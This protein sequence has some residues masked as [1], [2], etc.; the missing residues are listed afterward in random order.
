M[1]T[2][3]ISEELRTQVIELLNAYIN[4]SVSM[5]ILD[6][7]EAQYSEEEIKKCIKKLK[8]LNNENL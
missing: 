8:E 4:D 1:K 6:A 2:Y 5:S 3:R 7:F